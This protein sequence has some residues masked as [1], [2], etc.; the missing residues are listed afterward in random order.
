MKFLSVL[1][2]CLAISLLMVGGCAKN[3]I[4]SS[5]G[6]LGDYSNFIEDPEDSDYFY[7]EKPGVDFKH[8]K[9]FI[10]DRVLVRFKPGT[11]ATEISPDDLKELTDY[12]RE[13]LVEALDERYPVVTAPGPDVMHIRAALTDIV[14]TN[15]LLNVVSSAAVGFPVDMGGAT[16]EADFLDSQ[17][18]ERLFAVVS[19]KVGKPY[20]LIEGYTTYLHAKGVFETWASDLRDYLDEVHDN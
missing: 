18:G 13:E 20:Y 12:A 15:V 9:K 11:E 14:P 6:F 3:E 17:T 10:I 7:Y 16:M 5:S 1:I 2:L 8:Y 19:K 4:P